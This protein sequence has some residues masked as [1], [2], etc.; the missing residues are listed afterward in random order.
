MT[1]NAGLVLSETTPSSSTVG[2]A[3]AGHSFSATGGTGTK[4]YAVSAG[5][6][7][8]GLSL[9]SNG[10]LTGTP[11]GTGT[12]T[13][14]VTV[15][16][17]TLATVSR[18]YTMTINAGLVLSETNP[19]SGTQDGVYPEHTFS[20]TGGTGTKTYAVNAGTLPA[21]LSLASDGILTGTPSGTGTS[22][23]T[24]T[25]T[26]EAL[27]TVSRQYTMTINKGLVLSETNPS[28]TTVG[29]AYAGHSFSATGGT[30]T[31][32]YLV[33]AGSLPAGLSLASDGSLTGTPSSTG[34]STFTIT[35]TD[36][37]LAIV[38]HEY[39][40][41]ISPATLVLDT[42]NPSDG[43]Q[44]SP[45]SGHIF[46]AT[47]GTGTKTYVVSEGSLPAGLSLASDGS[48]TGSPSG[49]GTTS[50]T[51]AATDSATP[52]VTAS[53]EYT[54]TISPATLVLDTT[55]PP[56]GTQGSP[57]AGHIF[58][59]MGGTGTKTYAVSGGSL[60][61]GLTLSSDGKLTGSPSGI[62]TTS[63]TV[64][65]TDGA[66]PAVTVSHEY[67]MTITPATLVLDTTNPSDGIQGSPYSGHS[68]NAT[69]GTGIKTYA[70]SA[71]TLPA[72][73]SLTSNGSLTGTPSGTGTSTFTVTVT[74]E[75]LAIVSHEYTMTITPATL[76][77]DTTN[78][79]DGIQGSPYAGHIF[80][81]I[82]GTGTKTYAVSGGSLPAGL[83]LSSDG[84]LTGSPSGIGTTSFTV[85]V[86]DSAT[87]AKTASHEYTMTIIEELSPLVLNT[88]SLPNG[89]A[90]ET[91]VGYTFSS[92]GGTGSKTYEVI[93]GGLPSGYTLSKDGKLSGITTS[94]G[95]SV[96][97]VEVTDSGI[98]A[99][100]D[101][102]EF[103]LLIENLTE[104]LT[105][106]SGILPKGVTGE[107]YVGYTFSASGGT[108]DIS[109]SVVSGS[110]P[111]GYTLSKDGKLSGTTTRAGTIVFTIEVSDSSTP[112]ETDRCDYSLTIEEPTP[113]LVI[114]AGLPLNGR[115]GQTYVGYTFSSSGG[116][117]AKTYSVA[118]GSL[119]SG[120][121]LSPAGLLTGIPLSSGTS[122][123][124]VMVQDSD[125][126][127]Q[128]TK[129][130]FTMTILPASTN[131]NTSS[132]G[133]SDKEDDDRNDQQANQTSTD[134]SGADVIVNGKT[135]QIG[136]ASTSEESGGVTSKVTISLSDIKNKMKPDTP[137]ERVTIPVKD[138]ADIAVG[139]LTGDA[140][141]AIEQEE[142]IV[143][144]RTDNASYSL[145]AGEINI[146]SVSA[147][148]GE[149]VELKDI[150]VSIE[151]SK[152]SNENIK[153]IEDVANDGQYEVLIPPVEFRVNC[154][155]KDQTVSVHRFN[156][157]IERKITI[158]QTV[159]PSKITTAVVLGED[160]NLRHIPTKIT[161]VDGQ[162]FAEVNSL[163]NSCYTLVYSPISF[164]DVK[165]HWCEDVI[166]E[167][168]SRLIVKGT[169]NGRFEPQRLVTR[170][171]F[172]TVVMRALGVQ[173]SSYNGDYT[174]VDE[175]DWYA[176][177]ISTA[178]DYGLLCQYK[179]PTI[180]PQKNMT[181][182]EAVV[183]IV[184]A[185]KNVSSMKDI[186]VTD[187][188]INIL[189]E[190]Y[191][192]HKDVSNWA[193]GS[194]SYGVK[195]G[196]LKGSD[197]HLYP[198]A[199]ITRAEAT[200]LI[201]RMLSV[202]DLI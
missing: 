7:P 114:N 171:E 22:T 24:V 150:K 161:L 182:E 101:S 107:S 48:L 100:R 10:S 116:I 89:R 66:T 172:I 9:A 16:D 178:N 98:L 13:F 73:L 199:Y 63:F 71:G 133:S 152:A 163:T 54:M 119:P 128:K 15:T 132:S 175:N 105:L 6:L 185:I 94:A 17:E 62:G 109:Y 52:A 165:D 183:I 202:L 95:T 162:Y 32:T 60:P 115:V 69:G 139:E 90:G 120:L 181:R 45:Y 28:S 8:A 29:I 122:T 143:E 167:M 137:M 74:D 192:D 151:I 113:A 159:D 75:A 103:T 46:S 125:V 111:S 130:F 51:V 147:E 145:P 84:K 31:K 179:D 166:N 43:I 49:I 37:A 187:E 196:I 92:S 194:M 76:V 19:S 64:A 138:Q 18:D 126:P 123:F 198:K 81:A 2:V 53:H 164:A 131:S 61:A 70:V 155:Y 154:S 177:A 129:G 96:F 195:L 193:C 189:L 21:G 3:Y 184:S 146:D 149:N 23:F 188:E 97:T 91:Y 144:V 88:D 134:S 173:N 50:F 55:N 136:S 158:P 191:L 108:G 170:G 35:V 72:G 38:S 102:Q 197:Q 201:K 25:V 121:S 33:S 186:Q 57:Y 40:M 78:P 82:G 157:Y 176:T 140:V 148:L 42:T 67:T 124:E 99:K 39:T 174:D 112:A 59:A 1:I 26:D 135:E 44:G 83:T 4:T 110:L 106:N 160:G 56:N 118:S 80:S 87:P 11:S 12:S 93:S 79:S 104:T 117:G 190:E 47:G 141:K 168:G 20:A 127:A 86:T 153:I 27:A 200:V 41:T 169:S 68:F 34:T 77:L 36:E 156:T 30:G 58:S 14:T 180:E 85:S 5:S 142:G 65:V